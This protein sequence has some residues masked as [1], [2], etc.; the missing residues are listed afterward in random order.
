MKNWRCLPWL[1]QGVDTNTHSEASGLSPED[2]LRLS[3]Q[4]RVTADT[5]ETPLPLA[6][7]TCGQA[8]EIAQ[9][10]VARGAIRHL[11]GL[12]LQL[13]ALP[14][15]RRVSLVPQRAALEETCE[16]VFQ[17]GTFTADGNMFGLGLQD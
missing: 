13:L 2:Q 12:Q 8:P 4:P 14:E 11:R 9:L 1:L 3:G 16:K 15:L 10:P 5:L 7:V 17:V 6:E